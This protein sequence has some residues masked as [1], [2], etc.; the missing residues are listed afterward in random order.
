[1]IEGLN[2]TK[3]KIPPIDQLHLTVSVFTTFD[4]KEEQRQDVKQFIMM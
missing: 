1:M 4:S 3:F 2:N